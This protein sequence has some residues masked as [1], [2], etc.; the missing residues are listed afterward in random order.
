MPELKQSFQDR[1]IGAYSRRVVDV[2]AYPPSQANQYTK[3]NSE[4]IYS[5]SS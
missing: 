4:N 1:N 3:E 5:E 2:D